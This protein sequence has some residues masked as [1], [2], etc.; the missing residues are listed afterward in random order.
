M[1]VDL[2][3]L[4]GKNPE[5][6]AVTYY[7]LDSGCLSMFTRMKDEKYEEMVM[8]RLEGLKLKQKALNKIGLDE[9]QLQEIEPI[10]LHGYNFDED[11]Y[12]RIGKDNNLRSSRYDGAWLFFSDTQ[13]YMYSHTFD[14]SSDYKKES[15]EEYFYKD[16][17]NFST[18][19]ETTEAIHEGGCMGGEPTKTLRE[20]SRFSLVVPGDKFYCSISGV[21]DAERSIT[22]MKQKLREK[23]L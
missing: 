3:L 17:T 8:S 13:V 12:V 4:K 20:Y 21:D 15:T 19:S 1:T 11:A 7:F 23:K 14:M 22:A 18:V 9:D 5:Q 10:F 16:I 2:K 6:K